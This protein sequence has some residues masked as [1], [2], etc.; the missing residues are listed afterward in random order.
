[1]KFSIYPSEEEM[2]GAVEGYLSKNHVEFFDEFND[3][4][5]TAY[6]NTNIRKNVGCWF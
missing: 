6:Y 5:W 4:C 3:A 2:R 1:M